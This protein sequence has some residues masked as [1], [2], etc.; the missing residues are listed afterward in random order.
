[1]F[2][3]YSAIW[4]TVLI[5]YNHYD[6]CF[7]YL[8]LSGE[9]HI[10]QRSTYRAGQGVLGRPMATAAA[11]EMPSH[12]WWMSFGAQTP[13]LQHTAVR[14]LSQVTS[15]RSWTGRHSNLFTVRNATDWLSDNLGTLSKCTATY[16][17]WTELKKL[18]IMKIMLIGLL[19]LTQSDY[20]TWAFADFWSATFIIEMRRKLVEV[21]CTAW[22]QYWE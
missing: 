13:E 19:I 14:V 12:C 20:W 9:G 7:L 8:L 18:V 15:G 6:L 21:N 2:F 1:M 5:F 11:M 4:D 10:Q 17:W 3:Y 16:V 22:L